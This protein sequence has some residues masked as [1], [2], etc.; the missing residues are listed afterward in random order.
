MDGNGVDWFPRGTPRINVLCHDRFHYEDRRIYTLGSP[1]ILGRSFV[2]IHLGSVYE[3]PPALLQ[4]LDFND[5]FTLR[6]MEPWLAT[7]LTP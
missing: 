4:I 3:S 5:F 1:P 6:G 2:F 7:W